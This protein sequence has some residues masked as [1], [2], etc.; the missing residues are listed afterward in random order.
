MTGAPTAGPRESLAPS[1]PSLRRSRERL[2][3]RGELTLA[4]LPTVTVLGMLA[5]VH[6]LSAQPLLT[7]SLAA[8][9]FLIYLDPEHGANRVK[10]LVVSQMLAVGFGWAAYALLGGGYVGT[11]VALVG[12][13]LG[14]VILDVVH[15]PAVSTAL[16]FALRT[17]SVSNVLLF[18]LALGITALLIVLQRAATWA[19]VR[20]RGGDGH[21]VVR[22]TPPSDT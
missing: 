1:S 20:F 11:G 8:S 21:G 16:A 13:I 9:A 10:A 4:A 19:M 17:G 3:L 7:A 14:M 5:V 22:S 6:I 18:A 12:T 15:P 2:S